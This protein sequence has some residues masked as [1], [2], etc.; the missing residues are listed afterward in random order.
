ML[1][2]PRDYQVCLFRTLYNKFLHDAAC[3]IGLALFAILIESLLDR[4]FANEEALLVAGTSPIEGTV[5]VQPDSFIEES[6]FVGDSFLVVLF[7][8]QS[9]SSFL[10]GCF[11]LGFFST[12]PC[13]FGTTWSDFLPRSFKLD[14]S[15]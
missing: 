9:F 2:Y 14:F 3:L 10:I 15:L 8:K 5:L 1:G 7:D 13:S 4:D 6:I 11:S 12:R